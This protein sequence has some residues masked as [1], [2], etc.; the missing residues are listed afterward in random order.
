[1]T[2]NN[3]FTVLLFLSM[4]SEHGLAVASGSG[5]LTDYSQ[6]VSLVMEVSSDD[7]TGE[8]PISKPTLVLV[9]RI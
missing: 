9:G 8:G 3:R 2:C 6:G 7:S 1:M 5:C 4:E